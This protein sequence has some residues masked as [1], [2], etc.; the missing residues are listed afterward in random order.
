MKNG[1]TKAVLS[2]IL[3]GLLSL[4][5]IAP[6][7]ADTSGNNSTM[8]ST[9]A[10]KQVQI[11]FVMSAQSG[12][13]KKAS[14]GYALTL[15]QVDPKT[16]WFTDR[17]IRKAGFIS[18]HKFIAL[19]PKEF[20]ASQPNGAMVHVG[21]KAKLNGVT[22]AMAMELENPVISSDGSVIW[23]VRPLAGDPLV[24]GK[25]HNVRIFIDL[26]VPMNVVM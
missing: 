11:L 2:T 24:I 23:Q 18:T 19:W 4:G 8:Q 15:Y 26:T 14:N 7:L 5:V 12:V 13:I 10:N 22:H 21:M 1:L 20:K 16:L 9:K 17:P 6:A 3:A 25:V